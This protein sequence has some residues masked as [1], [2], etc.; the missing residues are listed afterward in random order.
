M[1]QISLSDYNIHIGQ[2]SESL[3]QYL[4]ERKYSKIVVL[5]DTLT[6][7]H[8]LPFLIQILQNQ[9]PYKIIIPSGERYK[10]LSTC[11]HIWNELFKANADRN[12]LLINLGG[13]VI[14]DMGGFCAATY[15]RG[16]PF[17]QIPTTLLSQVDAS[18]GGK[19]GIDYHD[20]KNS[21]GVFCN[22][23][24]VF[25]DTFF[26]NTLSHEE[27]KSGFAEMLKHALIA[28]SEQWHQIKKLNPI[29]YEKLNPFLTASL[30][31]KKNIVEQDPYEKGIRKSL[32]FG[33]TIGHAIES[34]SFQ[35]TEPLLHGEAV[36]YGM[37]AEAYLSIKGADLSQ[38]EFR[39]IKTTI[40]NIYGSFKFKNQDP[41][42]LLALMRQDKKNEGEGINFS[43][44]PTIGSVKVNCIIPEHDIL[45]ALKIS[46]NILDA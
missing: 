5:V 13:G 27:R 28:D 30:L 24:A 3:P 20:I 6:E 36:A 33:H 37:V 44:L 7:Q 14:G 2:I 18:I 40:F 10:T 4:A 12:T 26:L 38:H 43:L 1:K 34:S 15:K 17:I 45:E 42:Q 25:I 41:Q 11:Q 16:I 19:L 31:I 8:C 46:L 9:V 39:E 23:Q 22:P 35:T 29:E 21:I 32:N